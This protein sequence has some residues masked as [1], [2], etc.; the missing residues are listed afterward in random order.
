M[1]IDERVEPRVREA[2]AAVV[3]RDPTRF[4]AAMAE[5]DRTNSV[6]QGVQ[7]A[8]AVVLAV[9]MDAFGGKPTGDQVVQ[10]AVALAGLEQWMQPTAE[11]ISAYLNAVLKG[12][13][14]T[15]A[16]TGDQVVVLSFLTAGS[17]LASRSEAADGKRWFNYLDRIE[18]AI[19]ARGNDTRRDSS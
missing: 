18:A 11:E 1:R 17:L 7:L 19:E 8:T 5:F 16:L 13:P 4:E 6:Q 2:L 15:D 10:L 9:V 3:K 12:Q 14:A